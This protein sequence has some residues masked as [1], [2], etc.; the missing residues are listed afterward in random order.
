MNTLKITND[1]RGVEMIV[2]APATDPLY[3]PDNVRAVCSLCGAAVQ[4][5]PHVPPG[6]P[7]ACMA[8]TILKPGEDHTI[9]VT[10]RSVADAQL[11][12]RKN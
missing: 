3:F 5:R 9:V 12:F 8:C 1:M 7:L 6:I 11:F 2:C 4:H 10:P